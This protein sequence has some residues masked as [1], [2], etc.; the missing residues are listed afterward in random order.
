MASDSGVR[1]V[2]SHAL[3]VYV[4][5]YPPAFDPSL[6]HCIEMV[7]PQNKN[8]HIVIFL[9]TFEDKAQ[10]QNKYFVHVFRSKCMIRVCPRF[11]AR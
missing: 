9:H 11:C 7:T 1:D 10:L 8:P 4:F 6:T 2:S 5:Y 3:R